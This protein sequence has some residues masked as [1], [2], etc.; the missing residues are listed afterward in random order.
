MLGNEDWFREQREV[1][2][3]RQIERR[4]IRNPRVLDAMRRV[5]RHLFVPPDQRGHAYEDHPLPIGWN[6]TISQPYMV[7]AMAHLLDLRGD[8]TVLEIGTGSGY[9]AAVLAQMAH[10]IHTVEYQ[11]ELAR[12]AAETL[13]Q[14]GIPNVFVHV[15]DGTLGWPPEA[16]YQA[17]LVTA[18]AP[19][20]PDPLVEQLDEGGRLLVPVG[21]TREQELERWRKAEGRVYRE[22]IFPVAFVPLIGHFGWHKEDWEE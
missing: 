2:V 5:P 17:I 18:A 20:L 10:T 13:A 14:L 8:E 11:P 22:K 3:R 9:Q 21:G 19:A 1:M 16:P 12:R 6:A 15:G 7:A 4:G